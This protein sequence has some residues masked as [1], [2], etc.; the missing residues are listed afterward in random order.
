MSDSRTQ[1]PR[2]ILRGTMTTTRLTEASND[3]VTEF[4]AQLRVGAD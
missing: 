1:S 4:A 3:A 2:G